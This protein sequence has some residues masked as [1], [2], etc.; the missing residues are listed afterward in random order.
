MLEPVS[1]LKRENVSE[2]SEITLTKLAL[3]PRFLFGGIA[4]SLTYVA[5]TAMEPILAQR[6]VDFNL[7]K[8][9]IGLFFAICPMFYIT[10]SML[11]QYIP[12]F[13]ER[14]VTIAVASILNMIFFLLVGPSQIM[15]LPDSL[16]LMAVGQALVGCSLPLMM[17]PTLSEMIDSQLIK[18]PKH[19]E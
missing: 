13:I 5:Y 10:A 19:S 8:M 12:K 2:N 18:Y 6:L 4:A 3:A 17:I 11:V 1:P 9:E 15:R 7:S 14:R 16:I